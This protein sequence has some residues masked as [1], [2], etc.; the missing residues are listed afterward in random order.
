MKTIEANSCERA[1]LDATAYLLSRPKREEHNLMI[2]I[3]RPAERAESDR[4]IY[5]VV[6]A[7]LR[8]HKA[9]PVIT[10]AETIFPAGEYVRHGRRG[11]YEIYP[12]EIYP[13]IKEPE[14][15]GRYAY[16]LVRRRSAR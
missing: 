14:D 1:W 16:R 10:V 3:A 12:E 11:V 2:E 5:D 7:F 15:W 9:Q 8:T 13:R 6:D 4:R